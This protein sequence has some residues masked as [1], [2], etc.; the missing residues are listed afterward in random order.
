MGAP[1][2]SPDRDRAAADVARLVMTMYRHANDTVRVFAAEVGLNPSDAF[3]VRALHRV[4]T[5]DR[6]VAELGRDL[7]LSSA[8]ATQLVDRLERAG[9]V[10]RVRDQADRRKVYVRA[11]GPVSDLGNRLIGGV[12]GRLRAAMAG[13]PTENLVVVARFLAEVMEPQVA[14]V[15]STVEPAGDPR[16]VRASAVQRT[17]GPPRR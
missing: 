16:S 7:E 2:A 14:H 6:T 5:G 8:S 17:G 10:T 15:E 1:D 3:A 13:T 4:L 12:A 11:Q 9:L